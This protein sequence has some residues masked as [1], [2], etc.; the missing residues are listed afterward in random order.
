VQQPQGCRLDL[1]AV[2]KSW[3]ADDVA[4]RAAGEV[5]G[6]VLVDLGGDLAVAG[7]PPRGGWL[8]ALPEASTSR[9]PDVVSIRAGGMATSA[10]DVRRWRTVDGPAHHIV[11]PRTGLPAVTP[12]RTV[13][14]HAATAAE[15]NAASTAAMVLGD[16]APEWLDALGLAARLVPL[17]ASPAQLVGP[18]PAPTGLAA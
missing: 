3:L 15:A 8:V 13:T 6:G 10:Q 9:R 12:W 14:V 17:D 5:P 1:G 4:Q 2:A 7:M 16:E 18:W 11:D